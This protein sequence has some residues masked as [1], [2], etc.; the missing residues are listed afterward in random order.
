MTILRLKFRATRSKHVGTTNTLE[1]TLVRTFSRLT[2][3][4]HT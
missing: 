3:S 4:R 2:V 1:I